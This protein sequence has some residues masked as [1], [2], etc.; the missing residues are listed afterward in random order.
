YRSRE[1]L[2]HNRFAAVGVAIGLVAFVVSFTMSGAWGEMP[3]LG[4]ALVVMFVMLF[5][6]PLTITV[7]DSGSGIADSDA[8]IQVSL[9]G[10][11][12]R[13]IPLADVRR[14]QR[15]DYRPLRQFGGW[16]WRH[17]WKGSA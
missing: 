4:S 3:G 9:A 17:A 11:L 10:V 12:R 15:R 14:V 5:A 1:F 13:S 16:G 2:F 7:T 8:V 6:V